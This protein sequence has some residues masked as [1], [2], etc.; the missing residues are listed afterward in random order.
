MSPSFAIRACSMCVWMSSSE[1]VNSIFPASIWP[2]ISS[3]AA[4][5]LLGLAGVSSPT[6]ASIRAWAWL[7]RMSCR[8]SRRSNEIDS[9]NASTRWSVPP[10]NRPPQVLLIDV[11]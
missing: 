11:S 9:V 3:R 10:V 2:P 5:N 1:M 6:S 4:T 8:Y 7:P